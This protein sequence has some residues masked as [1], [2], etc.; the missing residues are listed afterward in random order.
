MSS[1]SATGT[2]SVLGALAR[3]YE[4]IRVLSALLGLP[5]RT[6][7]QLVGTVLA[8]SEEAE[9][10][11]ERMPHILRSLAIAST[12]QPERCYGE[13][14]GP[15]LWS[16]TMSARASSAGDPGLY[17]CATTTKAYDTDEN[18]V[19]KHA[20]SSIHLAARDVEHGP[21]HHLDD[22][23]R[24][25]K[26]NGHEASR[27]LEHQTL[28]AVPIVPLRARALHRTRAGS[29]RSTYRPA[30]A[31]IRRA[32]EPLTASQVWAL[33]DE[34]TRGLHDVLAATIDAVAARIDTR[35]ALH[36]HEGGLRWGALTF[37][38]PAR[39]QPG[40]RAGVSLDA[41]GGTDAAIAVGSVAEVPAAIAA[42]LA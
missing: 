21:D 17:V 13:L 27:L 18:R 4:P 8:T 9:E 38:H 24:R 5:T 20:L 14:R 16:E 7:R 36:S 30:L 29:R 28:G 33:A 41:H 3:P 10:L 23:V 19:L 34:P 6:T 1:E 25:A 26:H 12:D 39:T 42:A 31:M 32:A 11:L 40:R 15:V 22:V 2:A 35:P 37:H